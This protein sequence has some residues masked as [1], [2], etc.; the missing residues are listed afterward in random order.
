MYMAREVLPLFSAIS[1]SVQNL[2]YRLTISKAWHAL[3]VPTH[4]E[5]PEESLFDTGGA[6]PIL[7][8]CTLQLA[9]EHT[10]KLL[11]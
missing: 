4:Q 5:G 10:Q 7:T 9:S 11:L 3:L 1:H 6:D 2:F 8:Q